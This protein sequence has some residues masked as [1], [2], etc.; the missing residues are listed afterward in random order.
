[1]QTSP[2]RSSRPHRSLNTATTPRNSNTK[3]SSEATPLLHR[4]GSSTS[5]LLVKRRLSQAY[6]AADNGNDGSADGEWQ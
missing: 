3:P 1:M 4:R 2:R 6:G 5:M